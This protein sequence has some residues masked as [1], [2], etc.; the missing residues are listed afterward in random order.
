MDF[1]VGISLTRCEIHITWWYCG[2]LDW[3]EIRYWAYFFTVGHQKLTDRLC[4]DKNKLIF[5]TEN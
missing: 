2:E 1:I 4:I 3:T 5:L